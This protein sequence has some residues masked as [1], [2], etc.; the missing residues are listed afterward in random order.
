MR[1]VQRAVAGARSGAEQRAEFSQKGTDGKARAIPIPGGVSQRERKGAGGTE[2]ARE[3][4]REGSGRTE[5]GEGDS[6]PGA[7]VPGG[8]ERAPAARPRGAA[9]GPLT[10]GMRQRGGAGSCGFSP[11]PAWGL[12]GG[13]LECVE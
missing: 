4:G 2:R 5:T 6:G 12:K 3:G 11:P 10:W 1:G 9:S 8:K 7:Q 13:S